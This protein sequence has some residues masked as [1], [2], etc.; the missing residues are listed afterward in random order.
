MISEI[1]FIFNLKD[2]LIQQNSVNLTC[3]VPDRGH[4]IEYSGLLY[5]SFKV[6]TIYCLLLLLYLSCTSNQE[7]YCIWRSPSSAASELSGSFSVFSG[8][9]ISEEVD[10]VGDRGARKYHRQFWRAFLTFP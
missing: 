7:H 10:G 8:V 5:I 2:N 3:R 9:L 1:G 6:L 4:V